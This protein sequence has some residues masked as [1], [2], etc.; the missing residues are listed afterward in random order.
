MKL[1]LCSGFLSENIKT[2]FEKFAGI[3]QSIEFKIACIVTGA[4]G[5]KL[6]CKT[7]NEYPD[8]SWLDNDLQIARKFGYKVDQ[9]DISEM[10]NFNILDL[11]DAIWVEGGLTGY[12]IKEIRKT[13]FDKYLKNILEKKLYIGTSA[14]SMICSKSLDASEWYVGEPEEGVGSIPGLGYIDFQVYPHFESI[15]LEEIKSKR[16]PNQEYWLL[17]NGQAIGVTNNEITVFGGAITILKAKTN[18]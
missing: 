5:Y 12:L 11:Y 7:K 9:Y 10:K 16:H 1:F 8:L 18:D 3:S 4:I 15:N 14:G 6:Q 17:K 13:G 2:E